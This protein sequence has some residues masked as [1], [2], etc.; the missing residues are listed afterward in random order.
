MLSPESTPGPLALPQ[1]QHP[2]LGWGL[3]RSRLCRW[4]QGRGEGAAAQ[5]LDVLQ[6]ELP[7][8]AGQ[9]L[10]GPFWHC[11]LTPCPR[12]TS[13]YVNNR[14][15]RIKRSYRCS[16]PRFVVVIARTGTPVPTQALCRADMKTWGRKGTHASEEIDFIRR[17]SAASGWSP[18]SPSAQDVRVPAAPSQWELV[19]GHRLPDREPTTGRSGV[20]SGWP[21]GQ[22]LCIL[23][24]T[25]GC[26]SSSL[27]GCWEE[28]Q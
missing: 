7:R 3:P 15:V 18:G 27:L 16:N 19:P 17:A 1:P 26:R 4:Q 11:V 24:E 6:W 5:G 22:E 10:L 8:S 9:R 2:E 25:V 21:W 12:L 14:E 13:G 20:C 23:L 28:A